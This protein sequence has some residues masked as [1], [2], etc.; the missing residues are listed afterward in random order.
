M[1]QQLAMRVTAIRRMAGLPEHKLT[2]EN[3]PSLGDTITKYKKEFSDRWH[4]ENLRARAFEAAQSRNN[5]GDALRGQSVQ[6][7]VG[8]AKGRKVAKPYKRP[9]VVYEDDVPNVL[10]KESRH[11]ASQRSAGLT[12]EPER[13]ST[14]KRAN[15]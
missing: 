13:K 7:A 9:I 4:D 10:K 14:R 2:V 15:A 6:T 5:S 8:G 11:L 3:A 12:Y 1:L